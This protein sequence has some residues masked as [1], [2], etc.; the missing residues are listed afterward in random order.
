MKKKAL[1]YLLC[2]A[3]AFG[4]AACGND[5]GK[6]EESQSQPSV[7]DSSEKQSEESS[8]EDEQ[9]SADDQQSEEDSKGEDEQQAGNDMEEE[10]PEAVAEGP[11]S[12]RV[13]AE[14][15][16]QG[17]GISAEG[18]HLGG[19]NTKAWA[20]YNVDLADGGY[21]QIAIRYGADSIGGTVR[22][23]MGDEDYEEFGT[24]AGEAV[25]EGTG[26]WDA[27]S[28]V[29]FDL[30]NMDGQ[31]GPTDLVLEWE[32]PEGQS[33][34]LMN[35]DYFELYKIA[36]ADAKTK[37]WGFFDNVFSDGAGFRGDPYTHI[38]V[39][40]G[41]L[42]GYKVDFGEE[43]GYADLKLTGDFVG[44]CELEVHIDSPDG[45][46]VGSA[47]F[48]GGADW[49]DAIIQANTQV[50]NMSDLQTVTG[51][52]DVYF[53]IKSGD[54]NWSSFSFRKLQPDNMGNDDLT[55]LV[56][57]YEILTVASD[58]VTATVDGFNENEGPK[59]LFDYDVFTKYCAPIQE[60]EN[61]TE[62]EFSLIEGA[63]LTGYAFYTAND[64]EEYVERNPQS[65]VLYG[66][67]ESGEWVVVDECDGETLGMQPANYTGYG[68][69]CTGAAVYKD[70]KL[71]I[72]NEDILQ[73]GEVTLFGAAK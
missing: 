15:Y 64:N 54:Y 2:A 57:G 50:F 33:D 31:S 51:C 30:A 61:V 8:S 53:V 68:R 11:V 58:S 42:V 70:Y 13:E 48:T 21:K 40:G 25:F 9:Q 41:S 4:M 24:L 36:N 16:V 71:V 67:D 45:Q 22:L 6:Q 43:G 38:Y 5:P 65:W 63:A 62:I 28:L 29:V 66:K 39:N 34:Y 20:M 35:P 10:E 19:L 52:H 18:D 47:A 3:M 55:A 12:I 44:E 7:E 32:S 46:L 56:N 26:S 14:S 37:T 73:L 49:N 27:D 59:G 60:H 1:S 72:N 69:F 17:E 23:W